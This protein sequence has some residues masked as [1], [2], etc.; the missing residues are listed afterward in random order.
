LLTAFTA[1]SAAVF[2]AF[3]ADSV[4]GQKPVAEKKPWKKSTGFF[5]PLIRAGLGALTINVKVK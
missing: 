5:H 4:V 3:L 1:A 2:Y